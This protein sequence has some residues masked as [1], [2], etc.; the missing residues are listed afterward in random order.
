MKFKI[1]DIVILKSVRPMLLEGMVGVIRCIGNDFYNDDWYGVEFKE[2][3]IAERKVRLY[4]HD[5]DGNIPNENGRYFYEEEIELY[6][7]KKG[8]GRYGI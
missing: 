1:G 2:E 6:K 5:L 3:D 8:N 4:F 7:Q